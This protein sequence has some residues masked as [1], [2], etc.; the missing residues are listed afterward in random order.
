MGQNLAS[1]GRLICVA[2]VLLG[3]WIAG[4]AAAWTVADGATIHNE[5]TSLPG[6]QRLPQGAVVTA[7]IRFHDKWIAAGADIP[8]GAKP[9]LASC[10][11]N[12][13]NPIVWTSNNGKRWAATWGATPT[14][15]IPGE[16]MVSGAGSLLLFDDDEG[17]RLWL[18]PNAVNWD[19][20]AL[21]ASMTVLDVSDVEYGRGRFV[22]LFINK[23]AGGANTTY[24]NS[25]EIWTSLDG[26]HWGRANV[27]GTDMR[28]TALTFGS[29]GF[30]LVGSDQAHSSV[31]WTS[32]NGTEWKATT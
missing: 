13:C 10:A 28:F 19:E 4:V 2:S 30:R 26:R 24:G 23:F 1:S 16:L 21:P 29:A 27:P 17:T 7:S 8:A 20:V 18:T 5:A 12:G 15:S 9:I 25:D 22:A 32:H 14:G 11:P 6:G 31:M 3:T